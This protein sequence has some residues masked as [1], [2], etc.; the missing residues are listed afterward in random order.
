VFTVAYFILD[1]I[2]RLSLLIGTWFLWLS[3]YKRGSEI[4]KI[5]VHSTVFS[6]VL[7]LEDEITCSSTGYHGVTAE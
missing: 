3:Q 5:I 2:V 7:C 1:R 6:S 4:G